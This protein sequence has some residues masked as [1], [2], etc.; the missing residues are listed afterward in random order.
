M[1]RVIAP[2]STEAR[3]RQSTAAS[4][5]T[6][7]ILAILAPSP[8]MVVSFLCDVISTRTAASSSSLDKDKKPASSSAV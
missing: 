7:E 4:E 6:F 3:I 8:Q 5:A 1:F 2:S